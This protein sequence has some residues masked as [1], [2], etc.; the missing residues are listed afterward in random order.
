M[1]KRPRQPGHE[2]I[3]LSHLPSL[4]NNMHSFLASALDAVRDKRG[5]QRSSQTSKVKTRTIAVASGKGGAGK[6]SVA[7]CLA[8]ILAERGRSVCLVDVDLGLSN[9]DVL[10]GLSPHYT[11]E[12]VILGD[13][14]VEQAITTVRPGLDVISGGSGAAAL[15]DLD[16]D[17]RKIF[18]GKI[19]ALDHYDY[20]LLDNAPGI[21]RQVVAFCLAAREQIIVINPEPASVTD[22]YALLKVLR[23]NGLRRPPYILLNK[24]PQGFDHATLAQRFAAVCKKH[25]QTAILPLGAVPDDPSFRQAASQ[26]VLPVVLRPQA[27]GTLALTRIAGLLTRRMRTESLYSN[28]EGFWTV[29]LNT[30]FQ[31]LHL[32]GETG[33]GPL[34]QK[35]GSMQ[36]VVSRLERVVTELEGVEGS[37]TERGGLRAEASAMADRLAQVGGRLLGIAETWKRDAS[38]EA[39]QKGRESNGASSLRRSR[40]VT[41]SGAD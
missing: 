24:V 16:H 18:L 31:G 15:A 32:P 8:W 26:S 22:G 10:L 3:V 38:D 40:P 20:L 41:A 21:H 6:T 5:S 39:R 13:I 4:K 27:R 9:V 7:A 34:V 14:A 19:R 29:S 1:S 28:A 23:Q 36:E 11:L 2:L 12:D 37:S 33:S 35:Q 25:L 30:L 17:R